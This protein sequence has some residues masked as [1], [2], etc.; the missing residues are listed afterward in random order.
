MRKYARELFRAGV[1]PAYTGRDFPDAR[2]HG[3]HAL[4]HW[5]STLPQDSGVSLA[6][7]MAFV[8]RSRKSAPLAVGVYR[9]VTETAFETARS[10]VDRE[11]FGL[12]LVRAHGAV[13]ELRSAR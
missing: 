4:R 2:Q 1:I 7:V 5:Y 8:G 11:L 13:T 6:G 3:M 9:H 12:R 10:A